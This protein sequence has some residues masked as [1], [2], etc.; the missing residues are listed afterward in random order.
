MPSVVLYACYFSSAY[1]KFGNNTVPT[2][3][4]GL[5]ELQW[6]FKFICSDG[7]NDSGIPEA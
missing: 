5:N 6:N 1:D 3:G 7:D 2:G 4:H